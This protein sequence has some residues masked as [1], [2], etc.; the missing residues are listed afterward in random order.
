M[1]SVQARKTLRE[2]SEHTSKCL[3][4]VDVKQITSTWNK[5]NHTVSV[6]DV[7]HVFQKQMYIEKL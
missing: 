3:F 6:D 5:F 4:Y 7:K 2:M 1:S